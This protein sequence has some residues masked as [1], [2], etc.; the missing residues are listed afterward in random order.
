[1]KERAVYNLFIV[2]SGKFN[3]D[4]AWELRACRETQD[5]TVTLAPLTGNVA[6]GSRATCQLA[7][8]PNRQ[9][10]LTGLQM[11]LKVGGA[12]GGTRGGAVGEGR[13]GGRGDGWSYG[14]S[15]G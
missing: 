5:G 8:C 13:G 9:M 3:F 15:C 2:N 14:R 12:V 6:H 1:M 10:L 7:F 4:F 11:L